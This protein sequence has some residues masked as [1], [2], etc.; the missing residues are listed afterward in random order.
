M[1]KKKK[2]LKNFHV[3][4]LNLKNKSTRG[5]SHI[6]SENLHSPEEVDVINKPI[7]NIQVRFNSIIFFS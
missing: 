4:A 2:K 5:T 3:S 1:L 7:G 6:H